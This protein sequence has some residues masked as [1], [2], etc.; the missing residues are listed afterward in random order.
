MNS[1]F[2][3]SSPPCVVHGGCVASPNWPN[4]VVA[5]LHSLSLS[6]PPSP[7]EG[8]QKKLGEQKPTPQTANNNKHNKQLNKRK[9]PHLAAIAR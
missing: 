5:P 6:F 1:Q 4:Q 8:T 7:L 9:L 2:A 3:G